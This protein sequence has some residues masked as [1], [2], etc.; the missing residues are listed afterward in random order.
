[1]AGDKGLV[2]RAGS[3][4]IREEEGQKFR[5]A[6]AGRG[7]SA[8]KPLKLY[9]QRSRIVWEGGWKLRVIHGTWTQ[10]SVH[11]GRIICA[12]IWPWG[13]V[14]CRVRGQAVCHR[15]WAVSYPSLGDL[16]TIRITVSH[17]FFKAH[18]W[19]GLLARHRGGV[20]L[21]MLNRAINVCH[22][23]SVIQQKWNSGFRVLSRRGM[24][25][26]CVQPAWNSALSSGVSAYHVDI[27]RFWLHSNTSVKSCQGQE[28]LRNVPQKSVLR[29][30]GHQI[31]A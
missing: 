27:K 11:L 30:H 5:E 10:L 9:W 13:E 31:F 15:P 24:L 8:K 17:C 21:S 20:V 6:V 7:G 25:G 18:Y 19:Q 28:G 14:C 23:W 22:H 3:R 12:F 26:L 29:P 2:G 4:S 16:V 1:M